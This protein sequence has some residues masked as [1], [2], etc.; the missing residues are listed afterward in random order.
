MKK[1]TIIITAVVLALFVAGIILYEPKFCPLCHAKQTDA[2]CLIDL[3]T[4][5]IGEIHIGN[6]ELSDDP[7]TFV[8]YLTNVAGCKGYCDTG[9]RCCSLK[10]EQSAKTFNR[11]VFCRVCREEL[12]E[13]R[14]TRYAILDL[15]QAEEVIY[16]VVIG[17]FTVGEYQIAITGEGETLS[18]LMKTT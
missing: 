9:S 4:G 5:E 14:H 16:P 2:P 13:C 15:R 7:A 11:F 6:G 17:E 3:H 18:L 1:K 10:L 12:R 8:F